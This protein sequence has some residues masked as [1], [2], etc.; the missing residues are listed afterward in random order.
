M[1]SN[2]HCQVLRRMHHNKGAKKLVEWFES[3]YSK[4]KNINERTSYG[5]SGTG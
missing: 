5:W 1:F 3:E 4:N 2:Q